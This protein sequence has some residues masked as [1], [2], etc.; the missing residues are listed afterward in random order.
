[1]V[2]KLGK[3]TKVE[4]AYFPILAY[5]HKKYIVQKY[6]LLRYGN[7]HLLSDTLGDWRR[8]ILCSL[9]KSQ[10]QERKLR[11]QR[12]QTHYKCG[13]NIHFSHPQWEVT[14][15]PVMFAWCPTTTTMYPPSHTGLEVSGMVNWIE[16]SWYGGSWSS[17]NDTCFIVIIF[18]YTCPFRQLEIHLLEHRFILAIIYKVW[19]RNV[20]IS[21]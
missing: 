2:E 7:L 8:K 18:H 4:K 10:N 6:F 1:M 3:L 17:F 13:F 15:V 16:M 5:D 9:W 12:Q 11:T 19:E 14:R 20:L 21:L